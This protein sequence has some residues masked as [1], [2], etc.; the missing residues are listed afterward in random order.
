[1]TDP[2]PG[3][4]PTELVV[5]L[6]TPGRRRAATV[7]FAALVAVAGFLV[8]RGDATSRLVA[9]AILAFGTNAVL[10]ELE[11]LIVS[12]RGLTFDR[13][14]HRRDL[15]WDELSR[16]R[17]DWSSLGTNAPQLPLIERRDGRDV[18]RTTALVGLAGPSREPER[19]ALEQQLVE[20]GRAAGVT[21][22]IIPADT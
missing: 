16:V 1:M 19:R 14:V 15:P 13:R 20:A 12:D 22:Q 11:R 17:V 7:W 3:S 10:R 8:V 18:R 2:A 9:V 21:I 4:H 6:S 5:E